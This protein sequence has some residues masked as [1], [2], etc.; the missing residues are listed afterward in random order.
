MSKTTVV[1]ARLDEELAA[2]LD[3]LAEKLD[4]SKAWIVSQAV[5]RF[6]EQ[7]SEFLAFVQEGIDDLENDRWI[8]HEDLVQ[9]IREARGKRHAA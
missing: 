8:S 6:V 7:E 3:R 2:G 5:R 9:E 4:R 1:T